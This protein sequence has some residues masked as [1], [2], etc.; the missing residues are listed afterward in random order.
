[1]LESSTLAVIDV[2]NHLGRRRAGGSELNKQALGE[3][4]FV[5]ALE[6]D[7]GFSASTRGT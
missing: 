7:T 4:I 5:K 2:E 3:H 1:M 6:T